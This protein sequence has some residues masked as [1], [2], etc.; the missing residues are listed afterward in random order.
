[1]ISIQTNI[2][3]LTGLEH[4]RLNL[5]ITS[6][7]TERLSSAKQ[8]N[9]GADDP[10]GL[11]ISSGM[12]AQ[13]RG[14]SVA[15]QNCQDVISFVRTGQDAMKEVTSMLQKMR[16]LA[17]RAGNDATLTANDYTRL[18]NEYMSIYN[19]I[20]RT[21]STFKS[22]LD[23]TIAAGQ[24]TSVF[25]PGQ[26]K[27]DLMYIVD[28]TGSM[29]AQI[30]VVKAQLAGFIT[31]LQNNHTD[32]AIGLV[33][34]RDVIVDR[35]DILY[36]LT[37]SQATITA[38]VNSMLPGGGGDLPESALEGL[39][40]ARLNAGW[41]FA[42]GTQNYSRQMILV[43][44][45]PTPSQ[46]WHDNA[47]GP[48]VGPPAVDNRSALDT[49][50]ESNALAAAGITVHCIGVVTQ[51]EEII[52]TNTTGGQLGS[53]A[54]MA[55]VLAN[56][57]ASLPTN[58]PATAIERTLGIQVGPN[59]IDNIRF[60]FEDC[61]AA[62]LGISGTGIGSAAS[63]YSTLSKMDTALNNIGNYQQE[64]G[65]FENR[66][67]KIVNDLTAAHTNISAANSR[68]EDADIAIEA[69]K[70]AKTQII[71]QGAM[72]ASVS[73]NEFPSEAMALLNSHDVGTREFLTY[74]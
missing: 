3:A 18:N 10:S 4:Q 61:R 70:L 6:Q 56:I 60:T 14:M 49:I 34:Y 2:A 23:P 46:A 59:A 53:V 5:K 13:V 1:M 50:T 69:T 57:Q 38:Q 43:T 15:I 30:N 32:W 40:D 52:L 63:A 64:Y 26:A 37:T 7:A 71:Q 44:D 21:V 51:P 24:C 19:E 8:V 20:D 55:A 9:Y 41:R 62:S 11:G 45:V 47:A 17:V 25:W 67:Q 29:G 16:D 48:Y 74:E 65:E 66:L 73:A 27:L 33:D 68:I 31:T 12:K 72:S 28:T 58:L 22:G 36:P 54:T 39:Q 42:A 35:P